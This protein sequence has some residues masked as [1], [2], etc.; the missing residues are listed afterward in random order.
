MEHL[1]R[2]NTW[3]QEKGVLYTGEHTRAGAPCESD[4]FTEVRQRQS[5][6]VFEVYSLRENW[7]V[8]QFAT[9]NEWSHRSP[10][11]VLEIEFS[12]VCV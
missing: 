12:C 6:F 11:Q 3:K 2:D 10:V 8:I 1:L 7:I 4:L 5:L 9:K